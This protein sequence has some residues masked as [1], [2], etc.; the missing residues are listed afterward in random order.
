MITITV[1]HFSL[2]HDYFANP[3]NI[4]VYTK[5]ELEMKVANKD[6]SYV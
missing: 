5:E 4:T 6:E 1:K 3:Q 2:H